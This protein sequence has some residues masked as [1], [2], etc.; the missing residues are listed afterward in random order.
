MAPTNKPR[1]RFWSRLHFLLRFLGLTGLVAA[2]A[3]AV[4]A[5][6]QGLWPAW[7]AGRAAGDNLRALWDAGRAKADQTVRGLMEQ[8]PGDVFERVIVGLVLVGGA[9]AL[10]ALLVEVVGV[11]RLAAGRRSA[12]GGNVVVQVALA[13]ALL[14][15]V[16]VYAHWEGNYRRF[17]LTRDGLF[18]L[19]DE[20]QKDL[21]ELKGETTIVVYQRHKTLGFLSD[22][23]DRYDYAAERKVVEKVE[24]LVEQFREFGPRFKV[25]VL[26]A[27]EDDFDVKLAALPEE[28]RQ[29]IDKAPENS[30][31]FHADGKVQRLGF[32]DFYALDKT[33]SQEAEGGRGNLVLRQQKVETFANK[34]LKIEQ[35]RPRVAVAVTHELL[36]TEGKSEEY[37]LAGVRKVLNDR[38]FETRDL[39]LKKW[40]GRRGPPEPVAYTPDESKYERLADSLTVLDAQI[41]FFETQLERWKKASAADLKKQGFNEEVRE[42]QVEGLTS[43][44]E[45]GRK[46][47]DLIAGDQQRLQVESLAEQRRLTD[48]KAKMERAL[49]D[50]DLLI[51]PRMTLREI[52]PRFNV[53]NEIH[54]IDDAQVAAI[55]EFIKAGKPVLACFGPLNEP[56]DEGAPPPPGPDGVE[57]LLEQL[58]FKLSKQTVLFDREIG[59]LAEYQAALQGKRDLDLMGR[60]DDADVP[61]LLLG[62]PGGAKPGRLGES[63]RL[64]ASGLGKGQGFE[65]RSRHPR[66]LAFEPK[67]GQAPASDPAFLLTDPKSWNEDQP[68]PTEK[69]MPSYKDSKKRGPT[70]VGLAAEVAVPSDWYAKDE[71]PA[72]PRKVR[73]VVLGDGGLFVGPTLSPAK[74]KLLL[75]TCNWALGR[76]DQ[77]TKPGRTWEYPRVR[78]AP[79]EQFLWTWGTVAGLPI[80][81][82]VFGLVVV[83]WRGLR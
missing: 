6:V 56:P 7:D 81:C 11:L 65:L 58:G 52:D 43:L 80:L 62:R 2:G 70:P 64:T 69:E 12:F 78:M 22:K 73:V 74:E 5:G 61:P 76:D 68:F 19:P 10:L 31:F 47:R 72:E 9:L 33:A 18:T 25:I 83:M 60:G 28:L 54:R 29:A 38:G 14:V 42:Q 63:L 24:D 82:I 30:I 23:P 3:G 1:G 17:D 57:G 26:D 66:P 67:G 37:T 36:T 71:A 35:K 39:I 46:R 49:A 4:L 8:Q 48:V 27:R 16:N 13:L 15:G 32:N 45:Q 51:L 53:P 77:L 34:V 40:R 75:D 44:L 50:C 20:V 21:R 59:A 79:A 55:K 41:R